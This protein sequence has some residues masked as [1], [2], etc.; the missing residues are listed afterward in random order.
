MELGLSALVRVRGYLL[1]H[2]KFSGGHITEEKDIP[3][4]WQTDHRLLLRDIWG[5]VT[6]LLAVIMGC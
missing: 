4:S 2:G 6:P 3:L 5:L 1:E